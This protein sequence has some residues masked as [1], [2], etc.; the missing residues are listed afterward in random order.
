M[1]QTDVY[2]GM[3][4]ETVT[5]P[6]RTATGST[7]HGAAARARALPG[8][9][10]DPSHARLGRM[11]PRGDA[12]VCA[13]TATSRSR[14]TST[15]VKATVRLRTWPRRARGAGGVS[16]DQVLGDMAGSLRYLLSLP[17]VSAKVGVFGTCS[18]GRHAYLAACK[19]AGFSAA[20]DCWGGRVVMSKDELT[21]KQPVAP[22]DY[23]AESGMPPARHLRRGRQEPN[24][25]AGRDPGTGTQEAGQDVRVPLVPGRGPRLLLL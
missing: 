17:Y 10:V 14:P 5:H 6:A 12:A 1:Y 16:D 25:R 19:V 11:V 7:L 15:S 20:V 13:I 18:G 24:A 8:H 21:A 9:G 22:I 23:T 4:A 3:L 2:E